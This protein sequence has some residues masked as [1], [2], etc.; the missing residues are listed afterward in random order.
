MD[1]A[2]RAVGTCHSASH[3]EVIVD[4]NGPGTVIELGARLAAGQIGVLI[5]HA[6][7]QPFRLMAPQLA[8]GIDTC[9]GTQRTA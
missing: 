9:G 5:Q 3:T 6:L 7:A 2:I 8:L 4:A 1:A